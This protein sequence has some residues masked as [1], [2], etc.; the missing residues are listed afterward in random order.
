MMPDPSDYRSAWLEPVEEN[1]LIASCIFSSLLQ[2][3]IL[4]FWLFSA[5]SFPRFS[6][7]LAFSARFYAVS[8]SA[9]ICVYNLHGCEM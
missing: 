1:R 3:V 7:S 4:K 5:L 8:C 6:L 2:I 9:R